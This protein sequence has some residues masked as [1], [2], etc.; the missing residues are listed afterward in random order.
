MKKSVVD[1]VPDITINLSD[2]NE[3]INIQI[4]LTGERAMQYR[5]MKKLLC[6]VDGGI[7]ESELIKR[8]FKRG[9]AKEFEYQKATLCPKF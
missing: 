9:I 4:I 3:Q 5:W 1:I 7:T 2:V 8:I 6:C